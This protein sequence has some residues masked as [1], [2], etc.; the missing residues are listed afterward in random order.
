M[1]II[2][3][4][5]AITPFCICRPPPAH[6]RRVCWWDGGRFIIRG[7]KMKRKKCTSTVRTLAQYKE[8]SVYVYMYPGV[9]ICVCIISV[10]LMRKMRVK[11]I[12][13]YIL[14]MTQPVTQIIAKF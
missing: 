3:I 12:D 6:A 9:Y 14:K 13:C 10:I 1:M 4:D 8:S 5:F 7:L 11:E 2:V